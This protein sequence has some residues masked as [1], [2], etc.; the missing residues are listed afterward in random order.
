MSGG[1]EDQV[2]GLASNLE[3]EA[4]SGQLN[5]GGRAPAMASA[6]GDDALSILCA[7][8]KGSLF[9]AGDDGNA[10]RVGGDSIGDSM[11]GGI[12]EFVKDH[13]GGLHALVEFLDVGGQCWHGDG[14]SETE[15][16]DDFH[17]IYLSDAKNFCLSYRQLSAMHFAH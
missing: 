10:G 12:H 14:G 4:R 13:L 3:A 11:V 9:V 17:K 8:D 1:D 7:D 2:G 16:L 5:E 6:T 15:H